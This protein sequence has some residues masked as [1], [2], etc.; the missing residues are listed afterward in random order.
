MQEGGFMTDTSKKNKQT[1][2]NLNGIDGYYYT[3]EVNLQTSQGNENLSGEMDQYVFR[4]EYSMAQHYHGRPEYSLEEDWREWDKGHY[5]TLQNSRTK[6]EQ[7]E[8]RE[9]V[10]NL[11]EELA[12]FDRL[13]VTVFEGDVFVSGRLR[14]DLDKSYFTELIKE[15][16]GIKNV[17][18]HLCCIDEEDDSYQGPYRVLSQEFG[19]GEGGR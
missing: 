8:L 13:N 3:G 5:A 17:V 6:E 2:Q 1:S 14:T 9:K 15:I 19:L 16:D 12:E 10:I 18:N 11:L 4:G 7:K